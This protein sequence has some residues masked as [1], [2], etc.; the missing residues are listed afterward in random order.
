MRDCRSIKRDVDLCLD[1]FFSFHADGRIAKKKRKEKGEREKVRNVIYVR[2]CTK[3][4]G[5][6]RGKAS[7]QEL[8]E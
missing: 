7:A 6:S 4:S 1:Y 3:N 8:K 2:T 5:D